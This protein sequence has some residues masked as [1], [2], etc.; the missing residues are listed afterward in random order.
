L[1][2]LYNYV[3]KSVKT[4]NDCNCCLVIATAGLV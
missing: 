4:N 2:P 1:Q 3:Q